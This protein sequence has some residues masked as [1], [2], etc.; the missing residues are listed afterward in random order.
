MIVLLVLFL[1]SFLLR[2]DAVAEV[3][4]P[5]IGSDPEKVKEVAGQGM[6][7][8]LGVVLVFVGGVFISVPALGVLT[9]V[10]GVVISLY[11]AYTIFQKNSGIEGL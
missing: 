4:A 7:V 6:L 8:A 9:V 1:V 11:A 10:S 3:V 5:V 2:F